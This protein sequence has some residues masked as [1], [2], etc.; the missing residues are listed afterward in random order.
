MKN[1]IDKPWGYEEILESNDDYLF[2]K[3]HMKK[4]HKCSLQYHD[5]KTETIFVL[6]GILKILVSNPETQEFNAMS[7]TLIPGQHLTIKRGFI[8][9]MVAEQD[10]TYL[11]A[12]SPFPNDVI[13]IEDDYDR[14]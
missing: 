5:H 7:I 6:S 9:R 11:E 2:K 10:C 4:G 3:L 8:H 12:S 13:R 1:R 14:T